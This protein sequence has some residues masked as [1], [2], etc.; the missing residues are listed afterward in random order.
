MPTSQSNR[1]G[2]L[3]DGSTSIAYNFN[4]SFGLVA[5]FGGY[6][7]WWSPNHSRPTPAAASIC[8]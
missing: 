5:D 1:I 3:H 2:Y 4:R 7:N 6:D 8:L